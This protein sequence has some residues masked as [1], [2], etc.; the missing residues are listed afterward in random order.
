M[1]VCVLYYD[2]FCNSEI[3]LSLWGGAHKKHEVF[4]VATENKIYITEENQK[5]LPDKTI[6]EVNPKDIDLLIIPG[7]D[8]GYLYDN[9]EL[10]DFILCLHKEEKHIGAICGGAELIAAFGLLD[11]KKCTGGGSGIDI[12]KEWASVFKNA[13]VTGDAIVKEGHI[14]TATGQSYVEFAIE[15]KKVMGFF[16]NSD[17]MMGTYKWLKNIKE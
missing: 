17:D 6:K 15:M 8:P 9:E 13:I 14:I 5:I 4:S 10:R 3:V 1:K 11:G 16:E 2:E 7:G 12:T